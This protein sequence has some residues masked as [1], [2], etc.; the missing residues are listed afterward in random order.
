VN[1]ITQNKELACGADPDVSDERIQ[2][3]SEHTVEIVS[4]SGEGAQKCGQIFAA[5]SAR[6]GNGVW[7]VEIIP[8]EIQPPPR[9]PGSASGVRIRLGTEP[10]TNWGDEAQLVIAFNEQ[11]LLARHRLNALAEDATILIEDK[12]AT[13]EDESI[14]NAWDAAME[15]MSHRSYRFVHVPIEEQCMAIMDNPRRGKN[16][17][18][19]GLL[20]RVYG[21]DLELV[22]EQIGHKFRR[23]SQEVYDRNVQ[24]ME[25]GVHWATENLDLR[26]EVPA[27]PHEQPM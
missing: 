8:A 17:F 9:T 18:A 3:L 16:M 25:L 1:D 11:V 19:L 24:L 7:T 13:H 5:N 2:S 23:K 22:R 14:R 4:D 20:T 6:A 12:W 15:E 26:V 10:V 27:R 21:H